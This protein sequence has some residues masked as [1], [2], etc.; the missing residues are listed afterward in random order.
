MMRPA[1]QPCLGTNILT[2]QRAPLKE[3]TPLCKLLWPQGCNENT[4]LR[5]QWIEWLLANEEEQFP[6]A[7]A[8]E[9]TDVLE[10]AEEPPAE[11]QNQATNTIIIPP[12]IRSN[13]VLSC[14]QTGWETA[15]E[16]NPWFCTAPQSSQFW[17]LAIQAWLRRG[18][19]P[20]G[21]TATV[22]CNSMLWWTWT[23]TRDHQHEEW[24]RTLRPWLDRENLLEALQ[25]PA[26][27]HEE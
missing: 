18:R 20:D 15:M 6:V 19:P 21:T 25:L 24:A 8:Q 1:L 23:G 3:E 11:R 22:T 12:R 4:S 17:N 10:E 9:V 13:Q 2:S 26:E 14:T 5:V 27:N 7:R 16:A